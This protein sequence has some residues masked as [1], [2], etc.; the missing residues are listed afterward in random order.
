MWKYPRLEGDNLPENIDFDFLKDG[1]E[2]SVEGATLRV[3]HT[4]GHT[5][6]HVALHL[7][8]ENAVFSGDCILGEGTA[9][10]EDLYDY[11][12]SLQTI[13]DLNSFVVYP[14]HGNVVQV[15]NYFIFATV[16]S[17]V[18]LRIY[19]QIIFCNFSPPD[20]KLNTIWNIDVKESNKSWMSCKIVP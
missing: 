18:Y 10:F 16:D 5:T 11:M 15:R 19:M 3:V 17:S 8:E 9:V 1:Q 4:P 2:F 7:L 13:L 14:G 12:N 6:D 20:K